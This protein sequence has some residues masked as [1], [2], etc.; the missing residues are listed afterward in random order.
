MIAALGSPLVDG[1]DLEALA[2]AYV[3]TVAVVGPLIT[4]Y[5][6]RIPVPTRSRVA[7]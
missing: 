1:P 2:A 6:D 4:R 3:L 5:A 7:A